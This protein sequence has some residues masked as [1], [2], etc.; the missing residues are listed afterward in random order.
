MSKP[1][2]T[3]ET[4]EQVGRLT[5]DLLFGDLGDQVAK[6][7]APAPAPAP[8]PSHDVR[9]APQPSNTVETDGVSL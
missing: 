6:P 7:V 5:F 3:I 9:S 4:F 2:N 1:L 8:S